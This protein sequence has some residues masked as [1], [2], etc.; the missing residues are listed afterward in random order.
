MHALRRTGVGSQFAG[1]NSMHV[2]L[3]WSIQELLMLV[4]DGT[5]F[6]V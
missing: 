5:V 6:I 3:G 2:A 1:W 4:M